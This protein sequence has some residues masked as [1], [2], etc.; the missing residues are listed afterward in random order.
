MIC[1]AERVAASLR[2]VAVSQ[3]RSVPVM[4]LA[5]ALIERSCIEHILGSVA[6]WDI[7]GTESWRC[8]ADTA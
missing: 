3:E 4:S 5:A 2:D 6:S 7:G 1:I 8:D